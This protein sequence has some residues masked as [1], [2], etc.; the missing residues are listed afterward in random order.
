MNCKKKPTK[1]TATFARLYKEKLN[2]FEDNVYSSPT[3]TKNQKKS[4]KAFTLTFTTL[5]HRTHTHTKHKI[6]EV[7]FLY[8]NSRVF[9][10]SPSHVPSISIKVQHFLSV[11]LVLSSFGVCFFF[12]VAFVK[13]FI[14]SFLF[15]ASFI[16]P[17]LY[18]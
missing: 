11:E 5:A 1:K 10:S 6:N 18:V 13:V 3:Q 17:F 4:Y 14:L 8:C 2:L 7:D 9:F 12:S 16:L 15:S